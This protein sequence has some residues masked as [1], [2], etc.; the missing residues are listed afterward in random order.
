MN[1]QKIC[2]ISKENKNQMKNHIQKHY[3][4]NNEICKKERQEKN[5]HNMKIVWKVSRVVPYMGAIRN[6]E[7]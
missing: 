7:M 2:G 1:N 6:A 5:E 3:L 4:E